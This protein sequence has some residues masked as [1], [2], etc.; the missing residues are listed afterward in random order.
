MYSQAGVKISDILASLFFVGIS[1]ALVIL[2]TIS[3]HNFFNPQVF[4]YIKVDLI[5]KITT[6]K[7]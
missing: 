5:L 7:T 6:M 1:Q 4:A 3:Y 2:P